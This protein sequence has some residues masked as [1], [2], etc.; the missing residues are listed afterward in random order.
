[1]LARPAQDRVDRVL[2]AADGRREVRVANGRVEVADMS[3]ISLA[4]LNERA[5]FGRQIANGCA[6]ALSRAARARASSC[7][8]R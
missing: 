1:M 4:F 8:V 3:Q 2:D 7:S 5:L 6:R